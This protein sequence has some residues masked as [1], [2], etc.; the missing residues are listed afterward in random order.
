[1][2][3]TL[4]ADSLD[5]LRTIAGSISD[6]RSAVKRLETLR[7]SLSRQLRRQGFSVIAL[8]EATDVTRSRL[9]Q[10]LELPDGAPDSAVESFAEK[11]EQ[12]WEFAMDGW[13]ESG[14]VGSPED[15]FTIESLLTRS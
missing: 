2:S 12:A 11:F 3:N 1:M 7:D 10:V 4:E 13:L 5:Q 9:Y 15:F 8:A 6:L 14:C